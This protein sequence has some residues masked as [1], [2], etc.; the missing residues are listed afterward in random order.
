[1]PTWSE[2]T[3]RMT[4]AKAR[5]NDPFAFRTFYRRL[6]QSVWREAKEK[7]PPG[8]LACGGQASEATSLFDPSMSALPII[9]KQNSPSVGLFTR[10]K[11]TWAGFRP[12]WDRL[13]LPY[14]YTNLWKMCDNS[15]PS[16][17]VA[18]R[19]GGVA[20][21]G[22]GRERT[23]AQYERNRRCGT[24]VRVLGRKADGATLPSVGLR[25][26]ASKPESRL[27]PTAA[28]LPELLRERGPC[29][30]GLTNSRVAFGRSQVLWTLPAQRQANLY[31]LE[32]VGASFE[33]AM[34]RKDKRPARCAR[35]SEQWS[36]DVE[37]PSQS[38]HDRT[39]VCARGEPWSKFFRQSS[40]LLWTLTFFL[41][42][43]A[44]GMLVVALDDFWAFLKFLTKFF[45]A[46]FFFFLSI[47]SPTHINL[48]C[49]SKNYFL[50]QCQTFFFFFP[51]TNWELSFFFSYH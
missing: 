48:I 1:M 18:F 33:I 13:V 2:S 11:G 17:V 36:R 14:R 42:V 19:R 9:A 20:S 21:A 8:Q 6:T 28:K 38:L 5:P 44:F 25:L 16:V 30:V 27:W 43:T 51:T 23:P 41:R 29:G 24:L 35:S 46:E 26:N 37:R 22:R 34:R 7:L 10:Q 40:N 32:P 49:V 50:N 3:V 31:R 45:G 12:S 39:C 4:T 47:L 15:E